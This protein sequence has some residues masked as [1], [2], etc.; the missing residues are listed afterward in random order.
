MHFFASRAGRSPLAIAAFGALA[1]CADQPTPL[2]PQEATA[3]DAAPTRQ[4]VA[5]L[6]GS[7]AYWAD[8]YVRAE[9]PTSASYS[10]AP[11]ISFNR[12]GG[13]ITITKPAG[14]TGRYVVRFS[15]L[16]AVLGGK[17]TVH[18]TGYGYDATYCKPASAYL[19]SDTV[20]VRCFKTGTGTPANA[21]FY[22]LVTRP[23]ADL[24]FAYAHQATSTGYA[25]SSLGSW[26]PFGTS[27]VTRSGVGKYQ[28][29]F[30][31]FA[32]QL[33]PGVGGHV[34]VNAVGTG[35]AHCKVQAW[36]NSVAAN[37]SVA[38]GCYT[39]AGLPVDS[40]FT[41]LFLTPTDHLAYALGD[42]LFAASYSPSPVYSS[43]PAVGTVKITRI[44]VGSY[45]VVW[46]GADPEIF[47]YGNWQV[48]AYGPDNAQCKVD[49][50]LST[51]SVR[52]LC[53]TPNG[54]PVDSYYTV[55]LGS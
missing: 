14:T 16:S 55:L 36:G 43:N 39:A 38:V 52:I 37:M 18:V 24:A 7:R 28:V 34:Q 46:T 42:Q 2:E 13:A 9:Y 3:V 15:G 17:S 8:G 4:G 26:N 54:T 19:A 50:N 35:A 33:P 11:A 51:E 12:S 6:L 53:S 32:A 31:N 1:A 5:T 48:T 20:A 49:S 47:D 30:N 44:S 25:P 10:P 27:R 45:R 22:L 29:T 21:Q 40:K 41:V 23:Y